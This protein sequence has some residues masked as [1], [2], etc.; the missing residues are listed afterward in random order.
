MLEGKL[1]RDRPV[2]K[3]CL[4]A[5]AQDTGQLTRAPCSGPQE[6]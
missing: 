5:L 1:T 2:L 3:A 4:M 6:N